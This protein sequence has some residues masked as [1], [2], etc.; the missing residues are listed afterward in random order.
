MNPVVL[1]GVILLMMFDHAFTH[2][3]TQR[4]SLVWILYIADV[5]VIVFHVPMSAFD[6]YLGEYTRTNRLE[7]CFRVWT[8]IRKPKLIAKVFSSTFVVVLNDA[9]DGV[10]PT[11][12]YYDRSN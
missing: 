1:V 9:A 7:D 4:A 6:E 8:M 5:N 2:E 11:L 3:H 12:G 10:V